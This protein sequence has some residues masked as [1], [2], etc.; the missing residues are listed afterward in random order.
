MKKILFL[1]GGIFPFLT[2]C[3]ELSDYP[4]LPES[5]DIDQVVFSRSILTKESLSNGD[6]ILFNAKG[7]L[8][9]H[10]EILTYSDG[11]WASKVPLQWSEASGSTTYTAL[12]PLSKDLSYTS[13]NIY[14]ENGLEDILIA[15]DT[16]SQK[17]EIDLSFKHLFARLVIHA[18]PSIQE[19]LT[20]LRLTVPY[21]VTN[22]STEG[23][24]SME[25]DSL[26]TVLFKNETGDYAFILPP[27]NDSRLT[28]NL[29]TTGGN[30]T[31]L[32]PAYTFKSHVQY[33]C[34]IRSAVGI[35]TVDDLIA[36][37]KLING[38]SY[39]GKTL[40]DFGEKVGNDTIFYLLNDIS[41]T[42]SDCKKMLPIGY[43][44]KWGFK[45]I[46]EGNNHTISGFTVPDYSVNKT[47]DKKYNGLFGS[48]SSE[49]TVRNLHITHAK[50]IDNPTYSYIGILAGQ[51]YGNILHCSVDSSNIEL[52]NA[53]YIYVQAFICGRNKGNI[54]NCFAT[55][56]SIKTGANNKVGT[57]A[58]DATGYILNC[59]AYKNT[60]TKQS[61]ASIGGIVG[62]A[63]NDKETL[64]ISNCCASHNISYDNWGAIIGKSLKAT[65]IDHVFYNKGDLYDVNSNSKIDRYYMYNSNYQ[66]NGK[67]IS[68]YLNEWIDS[69][70]IASY[71]DI[72]F[73]KWNTD[74]IVLPVFQ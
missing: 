7:A 64:V 49:G 3:N 24:L 35:R 74:S 6:S 42:E 61:L 48:I 66:V 31:H 20:E 13:Q 15:Q 34:T 67:H 30:Y 47:V 4:F 52:T 38:E 56:N 16:L 14:T 12:Y 19:K 57:I 44:E 37:S 63:Y 25:A 58:G 10:N 29:I 1:L 2:A 72:E 9:V 27:M 32:L 36:F 33:E 39:S 62:G 17:Q 65:T 11:R 73:K 70:G 46:F 26:T 18:N 60:F 45:Y 51:N 53:N 55:Y 23:E 21:T 59:Y 50:T 22:I 28:V 41:L 68:T 8:N 54:V 43:N 71:P 69:I 5:L 40:S